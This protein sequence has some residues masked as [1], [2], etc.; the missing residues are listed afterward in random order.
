MRPHHSVRGAALPETVLVLTAT[1]AMLLGIIQIGMIGFLQV[2]VDGAAFIAAHE[3]ALGNTTTTG[4]TSYITYTQAVFPQ[5]GTP[6]IETNS[7]LITNVPVNYNVNLTTQRHGGA[8]LVLSNQLQATVKGT[9]PAGLLGIGIAKLSSV[10][11]QGSAIEPENWVS[12][13]AYDA[14]AKGY[15]GAS[16]L[17]SYANNVQNAPANYISGHDMDTCVLPFTSAQCPSN[18]VIIRALGTAEFLDLDNWQRTNL[19]VGPY[20]SAYTFAEMLCHQQLFAQVASTYF[21][22]TTALPTI[23]RTSGLISTIY[24]WDVIASSGGYGQTETVLG[25]YP[26]HPA[27]GC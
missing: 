7:P 27:L 4:S 10:P 11:V 22:Q 14:D 13:D 2:M 5:A 9:A 18:Q 24:N 19:G 8:S 20:S 23:S 25:L 26:L 12:D 3:Y 15:S 16:T 6:Q 1:L 21:S 17:T